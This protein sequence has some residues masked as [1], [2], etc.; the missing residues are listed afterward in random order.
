MKRGEIWTVS[1]AGSYAAKPRPALILQDEDFSQLLSVTICPLTTD[2]TEL[3]L[4]RI[5]I[6]PAPENGLRQVSRVMADKVTT[7]PRTKLGRKL[8]TLSRAELLA[9]D[10]AIVTFLGLLR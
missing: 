3:P 9:V 6:A 8:G 2:P 10:Q 1:A 7:V 5:P 4:F